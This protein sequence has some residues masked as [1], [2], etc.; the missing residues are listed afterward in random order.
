MLSRISWCT[1][2]L[3]SRFDRDYVVIRRAFGKG[4]ERRG[5]TPTPLLQTCIDVELGQHLNLAQEKLGQRHH[6]AIFT[7]GFGVKLHQ[8]TSANVSK[9]T[10][11]G[12]VRRAVYTC[13]AQSTRVHGRSS[14]TLLSIFSDYIPVSGESH[15]SLPR[16]IP[17]TQ[18]EGGYDDEHAVGKTFIFR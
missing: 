7:H 13:I 2:G 9:V 15:Y 3:R 17:Q 6:M 5:P 1:A 12:D 4:L 11:R 14:R 10:A 18:R 8:A 16:R